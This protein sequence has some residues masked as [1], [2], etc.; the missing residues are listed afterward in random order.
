MK[1][2][3]FALATRKPLISPHARPPASAT[4]RPR[5]MTPQL[6]PPAACIALAETTPA[7][8]E[9]AAD[10]QVDARGD[11]HVGHPGG[12]HEQHGG[13]GGDVARVGDVDE[14]A[15][16]EH[17][18]DD[19]QPEQDQA[20]P[21]AR[22]GDEALPEGRRAAPRRSS[23]TSGSSAGAVVVTSRHAGLPVVRDGPG[24]G[25]DDVL[26]R[27]V[28]ALEA[29]DA[30][31]EAQDLDAV[32]HLEDLGHVVAD[33]HDRE[34]LLAHARDEVEH[35]ARLDDA[36]RGGRL[37]HED[38]LRGPGHRARD[39]DALALAAGHRRHRRRRCP[40]ARRRGS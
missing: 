25:A 9:H 10:R 17:A 30:R 38:D 34:A 16:V 29:R 23:S 5:M 32:G 18:E 40:A 33:E 39:R 4:T 24:H 1:A 2:G 14:R 36:E 20:D 8:H 28:A 35:V 15:R 19:D 13:V 21:R 26:H 3:I 22:P 12:E 11:D 27:H 37:V 7:E 31:A 6:S